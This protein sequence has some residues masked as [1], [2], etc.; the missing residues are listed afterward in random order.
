LNFLI[1]RLPFPAS[2]SYD[3]TLICRELCHELHDGGL[4][5]SNAFLVASAAL[6]VAATLSAAV[7]L[8]PLPHLLKL[9]NSMASLSRSMRDRC[10]PFSTASTACASAALVALGGAV[11]WFSMLHELQHRA[12]NWLPLGANGDNNLPEILIGKD[13]EMHLGKR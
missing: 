13:M 11:S 12:E 4:R 1:P 2:S 10:T 3:Q 5:T 8:T 6:V 7:G 9:P